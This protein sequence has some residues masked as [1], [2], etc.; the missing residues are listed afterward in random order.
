VNWTAVTKRLMRADQAAAEGP[1]ASGEPDP[2][3]LRTGDGLD[4]EPAPDPLRASSVR[5]FTPRDLHVPR[6]RANVPTDW[7][8]DRPAPAEH[9]PTGIAATA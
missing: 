2:A 3:Q 1:R 7:V 4:L 6:H 8:A 5:A 9:R